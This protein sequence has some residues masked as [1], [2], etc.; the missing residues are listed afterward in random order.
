MANISH[1]WY[2]IEPSKLLIHT[3]N[4][5]EKEK[6]EFLTKLL[7]HLMLGESDDKL[8]QEIIDE[9]LAYIEKKKEAG[10]KGGS[11]AKQC[12]S[13]AQ[14]K[15]SGAQVE[16]STPQAITEHN[17]TEHNKES[18][19]SNII[20]LAEK[21]IEIWNTQPWTKKYNPKKSSEGRVKARIGTRIK[22]QIKSHGKTY[23]EDLSAKLAVSGHLRECAWFTPVWLYNS[24]DNSFK[25]L[26][27][28]YDHLAKFNENKKNESLSDFFSESTGF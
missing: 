2:K 11:R 19:D 14:A 16:V 25:F 1:P 15:L 4:M 6:S 12:S 28:K 7:T 20:S 10:R 8:I 17:I 9:R 13:S 22:L 3:M 26:E 27:G 21:F 24:V 18:K 5:S 23:L